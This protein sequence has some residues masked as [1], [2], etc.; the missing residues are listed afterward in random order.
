MC[1]F[2]FSLAVTLRGVVTDV[3]NLLQDATV[4]A[5]CEHLSPTTNLA[6]EQ[7]CLL[8]DQDPVMVGLPKTLTIQTAME[9]PSRMSTGGSSRLCIDGDGVT[10]IFSK[11]RHLE[12]LQLVGTAGTAMSWLSRVGPAVGHT[13][14]T[15]RVEMPHGTAGSV[16]SLDPVAFFD[17]LD[18][19]ETLGW[20]TEDIRFKPTSSTSTLRSTRGLFRL[21]TI[22]LNKFHQ[23]FI[24]A[25]TSWP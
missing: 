18:A 23:S 3:V 24:D 10:S 15:L 17:G 13:L 25:L 4:Q 12:Q 1:V 8:M 20:S 16:I 19:L 21:K 7:L 2:S 6:A 9:S 5:L 11:I 14:R 22:E